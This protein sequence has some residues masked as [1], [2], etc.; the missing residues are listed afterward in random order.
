MA[1]L[2]MN[3]M[4]ANNMIKVNSTQNRMCYVKNDSQLKKQSSTSN[5]LTSAETIETVRYTFTD[6]FDDKISFLQR[7]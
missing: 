4:A 1:S 6:V 7:L 2:V 5:N 3:T